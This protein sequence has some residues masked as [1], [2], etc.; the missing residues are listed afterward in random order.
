MM[1]TILMFS[2]LKKHVRELKRNLK[3]KIKNLRENN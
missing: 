1:M 2:K 3:I